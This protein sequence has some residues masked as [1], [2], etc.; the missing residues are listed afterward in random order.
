MTTFVPAPPY[1]LA[2]ISGVALVGS[3]P[4]TAPGTIRDWA[5]DFT[6]DLDVNDAV[7]SATVAIMSSTTGSAQDSAAA[8]L[9]NGSPVIEGNVVIVNL[10]SAFVL[11]S[12]GFQPNV[13][14]A[15]Q[16]TAETVQGETIV[17]SVYLPCV[18][19]T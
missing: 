5:I 12:T 19:P 4:S 16:I 3:F 9:I 2:A 8:A 11:G 1:I 17:H 14:Y 18:A 13:I 15:I 10:G 6:D 7:A